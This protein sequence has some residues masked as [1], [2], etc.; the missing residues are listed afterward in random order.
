MSGSSQEDSTIEVRGAHVV[1]R[2]YVED[3]TGATAPPPLHP[4]RRAAGQ[5]QQA[6]GGTLRCGGCDLGGAGS[7]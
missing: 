2:A 4:A 7:A 5:R 1:W 6:A 3:L